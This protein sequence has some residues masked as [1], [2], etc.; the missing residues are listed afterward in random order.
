MKTDVPNHRERQFMEP[1]R[2]GGWVKASKS[3]PSPI[4]IANLLAKGWIE[5]QGSGAELA[6]R[7]TEN[8]LAA[9]KA[10]VR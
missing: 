9:K 10:T 8:G 6:Y 2:G 1:L 3:P 5:R 7:I 4:V